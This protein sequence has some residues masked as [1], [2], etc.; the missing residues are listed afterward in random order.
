[1]YCFSSRV[2]LPD[3]GCRAQCSLILRP[4]FITEASFVA[5]SAVDVKQYQAECIFW[6]VN[7]LNTSFFS[8]A[9]VR[10]QNHN[11]AD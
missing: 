5:I 11:T 9:G 1:M 8:V 10:Y 4:L 7:R 3:L 6:L 2:I